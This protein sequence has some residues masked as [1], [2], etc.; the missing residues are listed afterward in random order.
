[1]ARKEEELWLVNRRQD[2][3]MGVK[4]RSR[5][6]EEKRSKFQ[7]YSLTRPNSPAY[8]TLQIHQSPLQEFPRISYIIINQQRR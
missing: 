4:M 1:M 3:E 5:V 8:D 2:I 6:E 7:V